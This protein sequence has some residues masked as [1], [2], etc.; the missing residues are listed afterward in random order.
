MK[1]RLLHLWEI[2]NSSYWFLPAIMLAG[3]VLL[4]WGTLAVDRGLFVG[5]A[6]PAWTYSG[7][8]E[9]AR[10][11][12]SVVAGSTITVAGV[13]FS[14][15]TATLAQASSQFGPRL[16][17]NFMRDTGNQV[18]LGTF[19]A[20]FMYCLLVLRTVRAAGE[21]GSATAAFVPHVSVTAAVLLAAASLCVLVYFIHHVSAALQ[22]PHVVAAVGRDLEQAIARMF[23]EDLGHAPPPGCDPERDVPP[24]LRTA[25][26]APVPS[27]DD[28]YLQAVDQE[29]LMDLARERDLVLRLI[30]RPGEFVIAGGPLLTAWPPERVDGAFAHAVNEAFIFGTQ[31]TAE[32]DV[33][34]AIDQIVEIGVR[35]L[36]PAINDPFTAMTC[37]DW[38]GAGL[39]RIVRAGGTHSPYRYDAAGRLRVVADVTDFDGLVDAAFNPM[40]QYGCASVMVT[41]RMLEVIAAVGGHTR[42]PSQRAVLRHHVEMIRRAGSADAAREPRD[43][44][45]VEQRYRAALRATGEVEGG[46]HPPAAGGAAAPPG[47]A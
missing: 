23:P 43:V 15:T 37:V 6:R 27:F 39:C 10:S 25:A 34:F 17:R 29:G 28:G 32:Q 8:G 9:G 24:E 21:D 20:T 1:A 35:A 26:A 47:A 19:V 45:D 30:A 16:L 42:D 36:S 3:S 4:A 13:V 46:S 7:G 5:D 31:R 22:A 11:L 44:H 40:R 14:I 2:W 12:L 18:V 41:L 38:L 33:E